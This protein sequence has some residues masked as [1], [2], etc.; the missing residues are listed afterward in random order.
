M[1]RVKE[2]EEKLSFLTK[3]AE[4]GTSSVE[5]LN[6]ESTPR[7]VGQTGKILDNAK[8][9]ATLKQKIIGL[10]YEIERLKLA[11]KSRNEGELE[12]KMTEEDMELYECKIKLEDQIQ[13]L[14]LVR[15]QKEDC[16]VH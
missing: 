12:K 3:G 11:S 5:Q 15:V 2:L 6:Q 9:V 8:E 13:Q 4:S 1:L 14:Q 7:A 10:E 16:E